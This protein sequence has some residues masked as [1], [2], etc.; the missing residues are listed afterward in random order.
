MKPPRANHPRRARINSS[1]PADVR[2]RLAA[3]CAAKGIYECEALRAAVTEYLDGTS[4]MTLLYRR[5]DS[6]NRE[7]HRQRRTLEL[8]GEFLKEFVQEWLKLTAARADTAEPDFLR[9]AARRY[10][11]LIQRVTASLSVGKT[12]V[13]DLPREMLSPTLP[14]APPNIDPAPTEVSPSSTGQ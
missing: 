14:E 10:Q 12:W 4:D 5:L 6:I 13:D 1:L 8:Q 9:R 2:H 11:K 7:Q 3:H